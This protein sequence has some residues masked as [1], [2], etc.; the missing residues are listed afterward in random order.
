MI[1][2]FYVKIINNDF[3][4]FLL[5]EIKLHDSNG[6][7]WRYLGPHKYINWKIHSVCYQRYYWI[8]LSWCSTTKQYIRLWRDKKQWSQA[9]I[10][11]IPLKFQKKTCFTLTVVEHCSTLPRDVIE[12]PSFKIFKTLRNLLE[13]ILLWAWVWTAQSPDVPSKRNLLWFCEILW[14]PD[15]N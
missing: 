12:S 3:M 7:F 9:K 6:F 2:W 10:H 13:L 8:F 4:F 15:C 1:F 5:K 14:I 11:E